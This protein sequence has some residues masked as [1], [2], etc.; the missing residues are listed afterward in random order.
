MAELWPFV[1]RYVKKEDK[2]IVLLLFQSE[3]SIS[4]LDGRNKVWDHSNQNLMV[5]KMAFVVFR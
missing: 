1:H 5:S 4:G 3:A 2:G